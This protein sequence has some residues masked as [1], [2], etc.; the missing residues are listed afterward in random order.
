MQQFVKTHNQQD[1]GPL[2]IS[3]YT[4]DTPYQ[5]D[6]FAFMKSCR[7]LEIDIDIEEVPNRKSWARNCAF[8]PFFIKKKLE[9]HKRAVFWVDVDALFLKKP[10]FA[11]L[12]AWDFAVREMDNTR[13]PR[14]RYHAGSLFFNYTPRSLAFVEVWCA[15][16]SEKLTL[17]EDP[18]CLD[19]TSL[20]HL[21]NVQSDLMICPLPIAY[22]KIF[23]IDEGKIS[24]EEIVI[25]HYQSSR[26]YK[27]LIS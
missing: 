4:E 10:D 20:A 2:V 15:Y 13:D 17:E 7:D 16:C 25:E 6:A 19:Q 26:R 24:R 11:Q 22:A 5:F 23:D 18:I 9:E 21:L 8:K 12:L 27:N 3:F 14:F 1:S